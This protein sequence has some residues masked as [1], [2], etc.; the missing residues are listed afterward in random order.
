[1][2]LRSTEPYGMALNQE[3][4][5]AYSGNENA[6]RLLVLLVLHD[7]SHM[8]GKDCVHVNPGEKSA[9]KWQLSETNEMCRRVR[10]NEKVRK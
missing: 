2:A 10:L 6:V 5:V 9:V 7:H 3:L 8:R 1:M 4:S